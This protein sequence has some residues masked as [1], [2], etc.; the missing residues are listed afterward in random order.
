LPVAAIEI[1]MERFMGR[2]HSRIAAAGE[3]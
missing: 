3:H 2:A 1:V